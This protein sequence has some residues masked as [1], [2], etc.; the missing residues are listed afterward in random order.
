MNCELCR[1]RFRDD[2][3]NWTKRVPD[4]FWGQ[5]IAEHNEVLRRIAERN[6]VRLIPFAERAA[7]ILTG[8]EDSIHLNGE[9]NAFRARL[10][11]DVIEPMLG[12]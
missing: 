10:L 1:L 9:A 11:A 7:E 5:G 2:L 3:P 8:F 12:D 4:R 6:D